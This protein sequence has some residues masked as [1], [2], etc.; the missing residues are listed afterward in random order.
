MSVWMNMFVIVIEDEMKEIKNQ[1]KNE[2]LFHLKHNTKRL[3]LEKYTQRFQRET[4]CDEK[5]I[6]KLFN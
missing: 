5:H 1:T 3:R 4:E 6:H 2:F